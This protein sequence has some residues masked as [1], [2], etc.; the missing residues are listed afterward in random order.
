MEKSVA[1]FKTASASLEETLQVI[2]QQPAEAQ[3]Q[4]VRGARRA[5]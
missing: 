2:A 1:R 4:E 3:L 5:G